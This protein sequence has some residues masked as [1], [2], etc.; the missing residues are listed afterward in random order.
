MSTKSSSIL[1]VFQEPLVQRDSKP[2][3]ILRKIESNR[4]CADC[5]QPGFSS[6]YLFQTI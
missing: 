2:I 5:G 1:T 6:I 3:E 4:F